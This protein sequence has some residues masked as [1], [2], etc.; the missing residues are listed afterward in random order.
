MAMTAAGTTAHRLVV[1][2]KA[3]IS[4]ELRAH[5]S[6]VL[7]AT[8][9]SWLER[10]V[11]CL[12]GDRVPTAPVVLVPVPSTAGGRPSWRGRHPLLGVCEGACAAVAADSSR[13]PSTAPPIRTLALL[14]P[15]ETPPSRLR[16]RADGFVVVDDGA[17]LAASLIVVDDIWTSGARAVSAAAALGA[18][19]FDVL[20]IVPFTRFVRPTHNA[21]TTSYWADVSRQ[22]ASVDHCAVCD[23]DTI[24][25]DVSGPS[26]V[27]VPGTTRMRAARPGRPRSYELPVRRVV[28]RLAAA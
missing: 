21:A 10:H 12:L 7:S 2:Y 27:A 23:R 22:P 28:E 15:S 9:G 20:A 14:R 26:G 4:T 24:G 13:A 8:F 5:A 3:A 16:P 1:G 19:G 25:R 6:G 18:A 11:P 17:S